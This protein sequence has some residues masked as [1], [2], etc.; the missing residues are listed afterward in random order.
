M[1]TLAT[2][3]RE[4]SMKESTVENSAFSN[5]NGTKD[6]NFKLREEL[7]TQVAENSQIWI[8][9]VD[10]RGLYTYASSAVENILGYKPEEIVGKKHFYDFFA[11]KDKKDLKQAAFKLFAQKESF[12]E[13]INV[14]IHKNCRFVWLSMSGLPILDKEGRLLGYRGTYIDITERKEAQEKLSESEEKYRDI[15]DNARDAIYIHDLKGK[16]IS[17]NKVVQEY[18]YTEEEIIGKNVLKFIPKK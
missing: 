15:F 2:N 10:S 14:N 6:S 3:R 13:F 4:K 7:F 1:E 16:V 8:W 9:E 18:G 12:R 5:I 17:I 11:S